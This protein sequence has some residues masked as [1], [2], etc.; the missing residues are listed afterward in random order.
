MK[1]IKNLLYTLITLAAVCL[2]IHFMSFLLRPADMDTAL[3]AVEVFHDLPENSVDVMCFG[4]SHMWYGLDPRVITSESGLSAYNFGCYYQKINTTLLFMQEAFRTQHPKAVIV[5][6]FYANRL[7][8]DEVFDGELY[9]TKK[10][11]LSADKLS[12]LKQC[13]GSDVESYINYF[14]PFSVFHGNWKDLTFDFDNSTDFGL[15]GCRGYAEF[16][17]VTRS[18]FPVRKD[19]NS[20]ILSE[21]SISVLSKMTKLC[22]ENG[23]ELIFITIPYEEEYKYASAMKAFAEQNGC[24]YIDLFDHIEEIGL[25]PM[26]DFADRSHLNSSGAAKIGAFMGKYLT[27]N[28]S[29]AE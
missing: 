23:A 6:T 5:D 2:S 27:N 24:V 29:F 4:S 10:I 1:K 17:A 14:F 20:H 13:F 7:K 19:Q 18:S 11:R 16:N 26:T 8:S 15:R 21:E 12:Y 25:D 9:S 22:K 3:Q 28:F